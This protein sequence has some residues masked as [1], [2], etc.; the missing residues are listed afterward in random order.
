MVRDTLQALFFSLCHSSSARESSFLFIS[1]LGALVN[2]SLGWGFSTLV[3]F[4]WG[5]LS[6]FFFFLTGSS[7]SAYS[8]FFPELGKVFPSHWLAIKLYL[9]A[10]VSR[11]AETPGN[12]L[13]TLFLWGQFLVSMTPNLIPILPLFSH[14][15]G[16]AVPTATP[17]IISVTT[18]PSWYF[19]LSC[20]KINLTSNQ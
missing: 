20:L 8:S 13:H 18:L 19:T 6:L 1:Q 14:C 2:T 9:V 4:W 16:L 11:G 3:G 12:P 7:K 17:P 15:T 10:P 5:F